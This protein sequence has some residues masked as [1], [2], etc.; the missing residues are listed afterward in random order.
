[1]ALKKKK[2]HLKHVVCKYKVL[3]PSKVL[4]GDLDMF[5]NMQ[6]LILFT[7]WYLQIFQR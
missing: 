6:F 3:H 2:I 1:M 4:K 7:D 5:L